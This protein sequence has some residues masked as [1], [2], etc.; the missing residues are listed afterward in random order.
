MGI[1]KEAGDG[2]SAAAIR[3]FNPEIVD[4]GVRFLR[5]LELDSEARLA[6]EERMA[7]QLSFFPSPTKFFGGALL[8][9]KRKTQRSL[10]FKRPIHLVLR[11]SKAKGRWAFLD[12]RNKPK[13]ERWIREFSKRNSLRVYATAI[14][15][16]HIHIVVRFPNRA[17]YNKFVRSITGTLPKVVFGF[18]H[19]HETFWDFRPFTRIVE[20]GR[21]YRGVLAYLL[22]NTLEALG[23]TKYKSRKDRYSVWLAKN[24]ALIG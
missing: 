19:P 21:D 5:W 17:L 24:G 12:Y 6:F 16:N 3:S 23:L 22:Q 10:A 4:W 2:P 7:R 13:I 9:G 1:G 15:W 14:S 11:S 18:E 8:C 20:W